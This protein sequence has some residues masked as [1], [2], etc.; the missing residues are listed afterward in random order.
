MSAPANILVF[1]GSTRSES[2]NK[3]LARLGAEAV[4]AAGG[5]ATFVD[6]RDLPMPVFDQDL[7]A[8]EGLPENARKFKELLFANDGLL[9][10]SPEYNSS[11][12]AVLKNSLD[13]ASRPAS[14]SEPG[15]ACFT[16]KVAALMSA[17]PGALGGL[18]GLVHLRS[19]LGNIQVLVL[20][21]QLA[22]V[23]ANEAFQPNG[24]LQDS[25][26]QASV[27]RIARKLVDVTSKLKR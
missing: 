15:L 2:Y 26:Q 1:A 12:T 4:D 16:G 24:A 5:S 3:K 22:I 19:I 10:A 23:R 21:D 8:R 27:E 18:R 25:N 13:W 7:E 6:L 20:P 17:S 14:A 11:I 9:I